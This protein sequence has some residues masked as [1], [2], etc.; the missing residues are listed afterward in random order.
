MSMTFL[1]PIPASRHRVT[2]ESKSSFPFCVAKIFPDSQ[3][4]TFFF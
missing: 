4:N 1:A 3:Q 2:L